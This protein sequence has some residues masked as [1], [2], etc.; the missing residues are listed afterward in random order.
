MTGHGS[1]TK[2]WK[3]TTPTI[4]KV[5]DEDS[6]Q[7]ISK[8]SPSPDDPTA[9]LKEI[10]PLDQ[11][12]PSSHSKTKSKVCL[13]EL[14]LSIWLINNSFKWQ[15]KILFTISIKVWTMVLMGGLGTLATN[16]FNA[17]MVTKFSCSRKQENQTSHV[18]H[19]F[20]T[21]IYSLTLLTFSQYFTLLHILQVD[22]R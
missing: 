19:V 11:A 17:A 20:V 18:C 2:K 10:R 1:G 16:I 4:I 12:A 8:C 6:P 14:L 5:E 13:C 3:C 22:S 21:R 9:I 7:Q 15:Q